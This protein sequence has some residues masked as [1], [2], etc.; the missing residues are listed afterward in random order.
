MR[1][2]N[3][4]GAL[5]LVLIGILWSLLIVPTAAQTATVTRI[6]TG[7]ENPRGV[8]V[9]AMRPIASPRRRLI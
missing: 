4:L 2:I 6:A 8:A 9:R 1:R 5:Q 7:L 3:R